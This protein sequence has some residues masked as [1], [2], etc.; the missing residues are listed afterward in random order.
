MPTEASWVL[1]FNRRELE[2]RFN[3]SSSACAEEFKVSYVSFI[4]DA[5]FPRFPSSNHTFGDNQCKP[6]L[7]VNRNMAFSEYESN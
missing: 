6:K 7:E 1:N 4:I 5:Q 2:D 3:V